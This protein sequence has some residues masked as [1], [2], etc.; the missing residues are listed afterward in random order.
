MIKQVESP[1]LR[2]RVY[3][4]AIQKWQFISLFTRKNHVLVKAH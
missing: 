1:D 4:G 2:S 3:R